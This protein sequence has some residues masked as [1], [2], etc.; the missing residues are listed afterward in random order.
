[1]ITTEDGRLRRNIFEDNVR[2]F[3]GY[4]DINRDIKKTII[5]KPSQF[6]LLNNGITVV[7]QDSSFANRQLRIT[8]PQ[9]V[10]GCQTCNVVYE[11]Y[12]SGIDLS[13]V[14]VIVKIIASSDN[15][16]VNNIVKETNRQN[17]VY[18]ESFE[19]TKDFHK[20][21]E[22]FFNNMDIDGYDH[23]YYERRAKQYN[24]N[25]LIKPKQKVNLRI[26]CQSIVSLFFHRPD[27]GIRHESKILRDYKGMIFEDKQSFYPY[28]LSAFMFKQVDTLFRESVLPAELSTYR[29]H[30]TYILKESLLRGS[31]DINKTKG[32]EKYCLELLDKIKDPFDLQLYAK[33]ACATFESIRDAWIA[34]KGASYIHGMKDSSEFSRFINQYLKT[35]V[36]EYFLRG[37]VLKVSLDRMGKFFG[38]IE[39]EP[40]NIFFH[41]DDN[42]DIMWDYEG[43]TVI[44]KIKDGRDNVAVG[45]KLLPEITK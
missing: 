22:Q 16:I 28:Y 15:E 1:M 11:C 37:V 33:Q 41:E 44:Y 5:Q 40:N 39:K 8:S 30:I 19:T 25:P 3:Q 2:D 36:P 31:P 43:K 14:A 18:E 35:D 12:N 29:M 24:F 21:L 7:C 17:I 9:V 26:L 38:F 32:I 20:M 42:P 4:T 10:N 6:L 45:V 27:Y 13:N 23:I 34:K